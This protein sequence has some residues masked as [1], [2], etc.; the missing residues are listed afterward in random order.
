[1]TRWT[2]VAGKLRLKR[3]RPQAEPEP[4][5]ARARVAHTQV[6]CPKCGKWP[7]PPGQNP[8]MIAGACT[9]FQDAEKDALDD[10]PGGFRL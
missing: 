6:R 5:T 10:R 2:W 3:E 7:A 8:G 9:C 4:P 1:M